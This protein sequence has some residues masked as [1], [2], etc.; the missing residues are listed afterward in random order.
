MFGA[1]MDV[2]PILFIF[3]SLI[4]FTWIKAAL[5]LSKLYHAKLA[6]ESASQ[7]ADKK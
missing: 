5:T 6:E 7:E 3:V 4:V 1:I 2:V